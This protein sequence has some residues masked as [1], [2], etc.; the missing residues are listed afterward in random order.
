MRGYPTSVAVGNVEAVGSTVILDA[1][2]PEPTPR[3]GAQATQ[4]VQAAQAMQEISTKVTTTEV[5]TL[6]SDDN[7]GE[8][9]FSEFIAVPYKGL[10]VRWVPWNTPCPSE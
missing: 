9:V 5:R 8:G 2:S 10:L 7:D 4:A 6:A 3:G 1:L